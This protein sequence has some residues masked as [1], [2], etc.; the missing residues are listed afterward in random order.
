MMEWSLAALAG[1]CGAVA[2]S[3][4]KTS[5]AAALARQRGLPV[6]TDDP[7]HPNGPLAGLAAGLDWARSGGFTHL[8]T[9]P[10][11]TPRVT[12][13]EIARLWEV[14]ASGAFAVAGEFPHPLVAIWRAEIGSS[15]AE[16]LR[17]GDHP[18][19]KVVLAASAARPVMF[20][21]PSPFMNVNAGDLLDP[22]DP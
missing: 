7:A 2:V 14:G 11:D 5:G 4:P 13:V 12:S 6:L 15:L 1:V 17:A 18:S 16:G 10:C 9:L 20:A 22:L 3:A 21:D 8:A 19:A